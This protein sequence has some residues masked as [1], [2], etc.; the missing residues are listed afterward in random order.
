MSDDH[1]PK[2]DFSLGSK[3]DDMLHSM[4]KARYYLR[5]IPED[6]RMGSVSNA[7]GILGASI[8]YAETN[9][10]KDFV[11]RICAEEPPPEYPGDTPKQK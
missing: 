2:G 1:A 7:I 9:N 3:W 8:A 6:K 10:S 4:K 11:A 5:L